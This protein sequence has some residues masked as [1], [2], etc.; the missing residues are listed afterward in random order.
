[1]KGPENILYYC[2]NSYVVEAT[3]NN[4]LPVLENRYIKTYIG[5]SQEY[6]GKL[7][8]NMISNQSTSDASLVGTI[9]KVYDNTMSLIDE[10][11]WQGLAYTLDVLPNIEYTIVATSTNGVSQDPVTV[12]LTNN[13]VKTVTITYNFEKLVIQAYEKEQIST[14]ATI[15]VK[16]NDKVLA[17]S[18]NGKL[19]AYIAYRTVYIITYG[20]LEE[21]A[22]PKDVEYTAS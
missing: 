13:E 20:D 1:M 5:Q 12:T 6:V 21:L 16:Y 18:S 10:R 22:K 7:T 2:G 9:V 11:T 4:V 8:I 17:T 14:R 19:T 15:T 3:I